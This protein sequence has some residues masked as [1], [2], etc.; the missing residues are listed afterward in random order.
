MIAARIGARGASTLKWLI[1]RKG[2]SHTAGAVANADG[3]PSV[4]AT[5]IRMRKRY[6]DAP[7]ATGFVG[8]RFPAQ[9]GRERGAGNCK[10]HG[11]CPPAIGADGGFFHWTSL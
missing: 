7:R 4:P 8:E 10:R 3:T 6:R 11:F 2:S 1:D 9:T 5:F